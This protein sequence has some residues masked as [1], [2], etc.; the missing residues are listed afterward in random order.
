MERRPGRKCL[1]P[2]AAGSP[3]AHGLH[4]S[5]ILGEQGS[6]SSP[7]SKLLSSPHTCHEGHMRVIKTVMKFRTNDSP[8]E[9]DFPKELS[10]NRGGQRHKML[11]TGDPEPARGAS[12]LQR[13]S[14]AFFPFHSK[15]PN[16]MGASGGS[17]D[18]RPAWGAAPVTPLRVPRPSCQWRMQLNGETVAPGH[19]W[20]EPCCPC[21][22]GH[23]AGAHPL[24][25]RAVQT[26]RGPWG[27]REPPPTQRPWTARCEHLPGG[28]GDEGGCR[29]GILQ[30]DLGVQGQRHSP[31]SPVGGWWLQTPNEAAQEHLQVQQ[32]LQVA[33]RGRESPREGEACAVAHE[34]GREVAPPGRSSVIG[35]LGSGAHAAETQGWEPPA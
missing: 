30:W 22:L 5:G 21:G 6:A 28:S 19:Y 34:W 9:R 12:D 26:C 7:K 32:A 2:P 18:G 33:G 17:G 25:Y 27:G 10:L 23:L 13:S 4:L 31:E 11:V 14:S 3:A 15:E 16:C 29:Q 1:P 8:L 35:S 24:G 20:S